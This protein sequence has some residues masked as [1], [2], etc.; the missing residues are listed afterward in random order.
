MEHSLGAGDDVAMEHGLCR[1][2]RCLATESAHGNH[3]NQ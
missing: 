3:Y 1:V 2:A